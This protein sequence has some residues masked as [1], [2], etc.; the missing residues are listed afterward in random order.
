MYS[1]VLMVAMTGGAEAPSSWFGRGGSCHGDCYGGC[2]GSCSGYS[3]GCS[4]WSC[5][6]GGHSCHGGGFFGGHRSHGCCGGGLFSHSCHGGNGC[7]GGNSCHG[8]YGCCGGGHSFAS[9]GCCGGGF[10]GGHRNHGCCGGYSCNGGN[11]CCGGGYSCNGG[12]GCNGGWSCGGGMPAPVAPATIPVAPEEKKMEKKT[13]ANSAPAIL[14]VTV[15][16]DA[17]LLI[18]D[19]ATVSTST[20]R[21]FVSP[22]LPAGR[23]FSYTL[24][25]TYTKDGKPVVVTKDVAVRAGAEIS[26]TMEADLASVASR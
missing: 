18:D 20:R 1:V 24:K 13:E 21:V 8:G 7:C 19:A 16:A 3:G 26:V 12:Y 11:G 10:F 14:T 22:N 23:E 5:H 25:A 17:K 2:S 15:P 4:G 9:H 6:G